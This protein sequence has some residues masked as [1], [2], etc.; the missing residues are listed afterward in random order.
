MAGPQ[1]RGV[2]NNPREQYN[3]DKHTLLLEFHQG[4]LLR[5]ELEYVWLKF[6]R[7]TK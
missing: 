4:A 5:R 6:T 1:V 7:I 3:K 2:A